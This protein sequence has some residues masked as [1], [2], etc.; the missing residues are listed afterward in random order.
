MRGLSFSLFLLMLVLGIFNVVSEDKK[1]KKTVHA[2]SRLDKPKYSPSFKNFIYVNPFAPKGGTLRLS[3]VGTF[4]SLNSEIV[5][6]VP[7]E[8][9]AL[10]TDPLMV[11]SL[12]EPF[13]LYGVLAKSV[14]VAPDNSWIL[15]NIHPDAKFRDG[16]PV[17]AHDI[18]LN[19]EIK[20]DK[21]RPVYKHYYSKINKIEILSPKTIK[22]HFNCSADGQYN[23][24][25]PFNISLGRIY[26]AKRLQSIDFC[27]SGLAPLV[28]S[29]P[30]FISKVDPGR[31]VVYEKNPNYWAKDLPVNKGRY[32]FDKV[33]IHYF[34]TAQ[35]QF[36][37][38]KAG[39]FD[40]YFETNPGQWVGGYNF[41]AFKKGIVKK[42][43]KEHALPVPVRVILFNMKQ[44]I[45]KNYNI[46]KALNL[47]FDFE[48]LNKKIF[49][50]VMKKPNSLFANTPFAHNGKAEG[51]EKMILEKFEDQIDKNFFKEMVSQTFVVGYTSGNGNQRNNLLQADEILK[52]EGWTI[53]N[54]ERINK[55]GK[56]LSFEIILKDPRFEKIALAFRESLKKLG[57]VLNIR[58]M[59][60]NQYENRVLKREF[61]MIFHT[62]ANGFSPGNEQAYYFSSKMANIEGSSNYMGL[63]DP[64]A[65]SLAFNV[66]KV[67]SLEDLKPAV[68]ALDRYI[69][70][71][72]Y[73]IPLLFDNVLRWAYWKDR[74]GYPEISPNIPT[75]VISCGWA[76]SP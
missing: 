21:G 3:I 15:Y 37:A 58:L 67:S 74:L 17:S 32:N 16:T 33:E 13:S 51:K 64:I 61:D 65:E 31:L 5:R 36:E 54:G 1:E 75:D 50:G 23:S 44:G 14:E 60:S 52:K 59:D 70:H 71:S 42:I 22:I 11:R 27:N 10:T 28:G 43:E 39:L 41:T 4:D 38:F 49:Y 34:K 24:E 29:G 56:V 12:D 30:Y 35:S 19:L 68:K 2:I 55:E 45:F 72:C 66:G 73:Q 40:I 69:M 46:R 20:R 48:S 9:L 6:G 47:A 53:K 57:I 7:A 63:E 26:S 76:P 62:W 25:L 8:S 18:K